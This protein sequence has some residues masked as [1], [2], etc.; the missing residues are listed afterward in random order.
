MQKRVYTGV[1][2]SNIKIAGAFGKV[3]LL[4][5]EFIRTFLLSS[6]LL[7]FLAGCEKNDRQ[8][9]PSYIHIDSFTLEGNESLDE[10]SLSHNIT[11]AWVYVNNKFIGVFEL[12]ATF[13]VLDEGSSEILIKPGIKMNGIASTR[14]PYP[15]YTD[16][17]EEGVFLEKEK[18][19]TLHPAVS[20]KDSIRMPLKESFEDT[21]LNISAKESDTNI[22]IDDIHPFEGNGSGKIVLEGDRILF[23]A[24]SDTNYQLPIQGEP[25]F[26]ELNFKT[27]V[28]VNTGLYEVAAEGELQ[29][30]VVILNPTE[31]WKKIYIN[32]TN[33]IGSSYPTR[34]FR[35]YLSIFRQEDSRAEVYLDNLKV[36][37]F[38]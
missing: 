10:G 33:I 15:F 24:V 17:Q 30:P 1:L 14:V 7:V 29:K 20:Y 34:N 28:D 21:A 12:P 8:E 16:Y 35:L 11:D 3:K 37:H 22:L 6:L 23:E 26:L 36:I 25:V 2:K 4:K 5:M 31:Q 38:K 19:D 32:F 9:I 27:N 13:P 18:V